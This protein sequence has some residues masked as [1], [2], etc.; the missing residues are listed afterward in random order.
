MRAVLKWT[1]RLL[2][3]SLATGCG[4][5]LYWANGQNRELD[6]GESYQA[7]AI[8]PGQI[9]TVNG[10][11]LHVLVKGDLR[12][13]PTGAPL[14][15]LHGFSASGHTTWLPWAE[16]LADR[17][18]LVLVDM[19]NFGYSERITTPDDDLTH[20]GQAALVNGLVEALGLQRFDLVGWSM[21]GAIATQYTL[22]YPAKVRAIAFVAGHIYGFDRF[23]PFK[24]L[25]D[26]PLG[27]GRALSW[28]SAGGSPNGFVARTCQ[29]TGQQCNWLEPLLI[30]DTI[31]GL[32]AISA[33]PQRTRLPDDI[34]LIDK[35]VLV[36]AG[37]LDNIVPLADNEKLAEVLDAELFVAAGAGHWP[38]EQEPERVATHMLEFFAANAEV[39]AASV[40]NRKSPGVSSRHELTGEY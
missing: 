14:V 38:A 33:T 30:E 9:I 19:L 24:M 40:R 13:D 29:E 11:R 16:Q 3:L 8:A 18:S 31:D 4:L 26:L 15:L 23:N 25:G 2:L 32:R 39:A 7:A 17:R 28:N 22:D 36:I 6:A 34:P 5:M 12:A 27:I 10:R 20:Q 1:G 35:P 37:E 21:G